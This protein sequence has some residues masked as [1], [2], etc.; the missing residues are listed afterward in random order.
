MIKSIDS[1]GSKELKLQLPTSLLMQAE[2][3]I[4]SQGALIGHI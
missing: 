1:V 3:M 2:L 4:S